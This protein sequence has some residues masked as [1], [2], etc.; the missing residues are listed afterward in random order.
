MCADVV[1][2]KCI[3]PKWLRNLTALSVTA[4]RPASTNTPG[5]HIRK[6]KHGSNILRGRRDLYAELPNQTS[7]LTFEKRGPR[8]G[9]RGAHHVDVHI[10]WAAPRPGPSHS[11]YHGPVQLIKFSNS[12]LGPAR[13]VTFP[14]DSARPGPVHHNFQIDPTWPC[15]ARPGLSAHDKP[16]C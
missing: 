16:C 5:M 6:F 11:I 2:W 12:R 15:S 7:R 9:P 4:S 8:H 14:K 1:S 3:V 10:S 13:P